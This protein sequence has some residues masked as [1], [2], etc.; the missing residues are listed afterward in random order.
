MSPSRDSHVPKAN[1]ASPRGR[2]RGY[3]ARD[4]YD[5]VRFSRPRFWGPV[6]AVG[7]TILLP[8]HSTHAQQFQPRWRPPNWVGEV[9]FLGANS[10]LGALTGGV[11]QKI[12][13]G[14]FADGFARGALGGGIVYLGKRVTV[15]RF[16]GAGLLARE[17]AAV[18]TS[19]VRN[20]GDGVPTLSR[21]TFPVGPT[22]LHVRPADERPLRMSVDMAELIW[23]TYGIA[24]PAL[25]LQVG[26]SLSAGSAVFL[27]ENRSIRLND[28]EVGGVT[29][30]GTILLAGR[31]AT[32]SDAVFAHERVHVI[33]RD[34]YSQAWFLPL[35]RWLLRNTP[36]APVQRYVDF[37]ILTS[38]YLS[39]WSAVV[40]RDDRLEEIEADFLQIR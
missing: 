19:I 4:W 37:N 40:A 38:L 39:G 12:G 24:E 3:W 32:D 34:F 22:R 11:L 13:G 29:G 15:A 25:A 9:T 33:Q 5:V 2:Y 10:L 18:G 35:E 27:A 26:K 36:I 30:P 21:F 28:E 7:V 20:A 23:M 14:S 17:I 8:P 1:T 6:L 16:D 31:G